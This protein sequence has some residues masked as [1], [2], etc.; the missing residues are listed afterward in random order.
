VLWLWLFG[1]KTTHVCYGY[2]CLVLKLR[3]CV[4]VMV[5]WYSSYA[6]VLWLWLFE[7]STKTMHMCYGY[8]CS[9][10][11]VKLRTYFMVMVVSSNF[12]TGYQ[13]LRRLFTGLKHNLLICLFT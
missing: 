1:T 6:R 3:T 13:Q 5:V 10:V 8:G 12:V 2:G 9:S 4:M 7:H 11:V